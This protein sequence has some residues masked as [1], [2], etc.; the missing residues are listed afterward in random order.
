MCVRRQA[1]L[2]SHELKLCGLD[3]SAY[4]GVLVLLNDLS[5]QPDVLHADAAA[6]SL[7]KDLSQSC[8]NVPRF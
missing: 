6:T 3:C 1:S 5:H 4:A 7:E 2:L 8:S